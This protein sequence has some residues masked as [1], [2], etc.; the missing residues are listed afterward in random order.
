MEE[1]WRILMTDVWLMPEQITRLAELSAEVTQPCQCAKRTF[2]AWDSIPVTFPEELLECIGKVSAPTESEL[3]VKEYHPQRT[4]YWSP[5][6]PIALHYFPANRSEVWQ[7]TRCKRCYLRYTEFG[8]YYIEK[9]IRAL[10][11]ALLTTVSA[12]E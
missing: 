10:Q 4:N 3:T 2:E 5:E 11:P 9:R 1:R 12:P 8:G 7:C 6:A